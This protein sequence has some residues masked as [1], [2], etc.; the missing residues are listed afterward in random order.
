[1]GNLNVANRTLAIMDNL[2]FLR[3]LNNECIDLI[4]I[5]PPFAANETFTGNPRPPISDAEYA[6]EIALALAHG[7]EHNEGRGETRV[8]DIWSWDEDV[9]P[10]WKMRIED[11]YPSVHA[12]IQAVEACASENEAAYIAFMAARLLECRRVLKPT[13]S[14]YLHCDSHANGYLRMLMDAVFGTDNFRSIITWRRAIAHNDAHRYGN[15]TDTLFYYTNGTGYTWN[16]TAVAEPKTAE[17]LATAY[18]S[19]DERGAHRT[20][21]LTGAG[22]TEGESGQAWRGYDVGARGRHWAPPRASSYARWIDTNIIPGYLQIEGVHNR[23]DALDANGLIHHPTR[24]VWPGLKR[25]AEADQGNPPQNLILEP[26]GFTNYRGRAEATGYATQKPLALYERIVRASSNPGDVVM[27]IFAGCATTAIAAE[28]LGRQWIACDMAYRAWTMLKRRF[29]LN[30]IALEGMT[31]ATKDALAS[32]RKDR[33]FQEPQQ[34]T[35]SRT[36][37]PGEL[38]E[39]DDV[40]PAPHHNLRQPRRGA[41]QSTQSSSW[42][43]RIPKDDAKRLLMDQF[44]PVCWGCGYE[45]RRP[46][47][48]LDE[49]LLEVDHIRARRAAQGTQGN[50]ELY[51][52]A[53][54]HRT[55]NG[56][57]RNQMTLEELRNHNA[58]NGLLYVNTINDLVDLYEATQFAAE[59]IAIHTAK[60]GL[61]T[62]MAE[63]ESNPSEA[64]AP[65]LI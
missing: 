54:L 18:P 11:D 28:Q 50:D 4:A 14:I 49:T 21:N 25:Y 1:M 41:R 48:S 31:D 16:G 36:I 34:W 33:G 10:A 32:V 62:E 7:V 30:G 29:Y 13:G 37:G 3:R 9:H 65:R 23:L 8:R 57:K 5:D 35:T 45:P 60:Y 44:G 56:V 59:Q 61:Q 42:S 51:N 26:T 63:L 24:G 6:E 27:D 52:L 15:I 12:V 38:P 46:N 40:D 2:A 43:G 22:T 19:H 20:E 39:R 64:S 17:Q 55:C 58:M 47:G 53:L